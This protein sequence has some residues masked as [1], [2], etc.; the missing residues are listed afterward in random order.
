MVLHPKTS[1]HDMNAT[2]EEGEVLAGGSNLDAR[3][4]RSSKRAENFAERRPK[5]L[6]RPSTTPLG[7][8]VAAAALGILLISSVAG[9]LIACV[10]ASVLFGATPREVLPGVTAR[11]LADS[12]NHPGLPPDLGHER[13]SRPA[14][15]TTRAVLNMRVGSDFTV[16]EECLGSLADYLVGVYAGLENSTASTMLTSEAMK[17]RMFSAPLGADN[18][19]SDLH[20]ARRL[21]EFTLPRVLAAVLAS[22]ALGGVAFSVLHIPAVAG[23]HYDSMWLAGSVLV[24]LGVG[25]LVISGFISGLMEW[26]RRKGPDRNGGSPRRRDIL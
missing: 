10:K 8:Y 2:E 22:V 12:Q 20:S 16:G 25:L 18:R 21:P 7:V 17:A 24:S 15:G 9:R 23:E 11:K 4:G 19:Q 26:E 1:P 13:E 3:V 14:A 6:R 5:P